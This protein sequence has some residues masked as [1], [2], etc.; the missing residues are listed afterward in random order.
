MDYDPINHL[1]LSCPSGGEFYICQENESQFLGCCEVD[2]C[3]GNGGQC[4]SSALHPSSFDRDKYSEIP[5]QSCISSTRNG[6]WYTCSVGPTFLGCCS[7]NPC[8][9][10]GVCPQSNLVGA[11]L[12]SNQNSASVFLT[13]PTPSSTSTSTSLTQ[14]STT[15]S[16]STSLQTTSTSD[17]TASS[18]SSPSPSAVSGK[19]SGPPIAGI[20]GGILGGITA[21]GLIALAFFLYRRRRRRTLATTQ[22]GK[23]AMATPQPWSPFQDSFHSSSAVTPAPV[24]PPSTVSTPRSLSASFGSIIGLKRSGGRKRWSSRSSAGR[25][26]IDADWL[27][28]AHDNQLAGQGF[29]SPVMELDSSPV[30]ERR[31]ARPSHAGYHEVEGSVPTVRRREMAS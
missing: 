5:P 3:G 12:N 14:T 18:T 11:T 28:V 24:S 31:A 10:D 6:L 22:S 2:P 1:G 27:Q 30:D 8:N 15:A 7:S 17:S 13:T 4:P 20:V 29:L 16:T 25:D 23:D 19:G 21:L 26:T 9:N